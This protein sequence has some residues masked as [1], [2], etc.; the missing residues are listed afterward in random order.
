M[1]IFR[2][3]I[4]QFNGHFF[5]QRQVSINYRRNLF[6][7]VSIPFMYIYSIIASP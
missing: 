3:N 5:N 7:F 1:G 6:S 2:L 4:P